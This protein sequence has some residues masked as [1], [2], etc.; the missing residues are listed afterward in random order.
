[1]IYTAQ[2]LVDQLATMIRMK[3]SL[4]DWPVHVL[5]DDNEDEA[6]H[7]L[8]TD[9]EMDMYSEEQGWVISLYSDRNAMQ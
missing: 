7:G 6:T 5:A 4:A 2:Q 3:P 9:I 8:L 1:M